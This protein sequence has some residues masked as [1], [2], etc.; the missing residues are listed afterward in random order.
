MHSAL[1]RAF[2][3]CYCFVTIGL[4][5]GQ[6][7]LVLWGDTAPCPTPAATGIRLVVFTADIISVARSY[8]SFWQRAMSSVCRP[9]ASASR[10]SRSALSTFSRTRD[11]RAVSVFFLR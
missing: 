8:S 10:W 2:Y 7:K 9:R 11:S 3:W 1:R 6:Y 5:I 4:D